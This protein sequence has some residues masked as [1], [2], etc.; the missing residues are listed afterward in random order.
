MAKESGFTIETWNK[1]KIVAA[2]LGGLLAVNLGSEDPPTFNILEWKPKNATNK[3]PIVLVGKGIVYD[4]GG[5]SLKP[6]ANSMDH[7]KC[8]M[9]GAAAVAGALHC[10]AKNKLDKHVIVLIPA[11]DNR[12]GKNAYVPGDVIKM[13]SGSTVEVLNTDAEGRMV[14]ADSLSY[15]K[16]YSPELVIDVATL[17]GSS[18]MALGPEGIVMM[19]TAGK[20]VKESIS[21]SGDQ[22]H[23][24]LV[25]F[26]IWDAYAKYLE[27]DIADLK[28]IGGR[29]AGSITAGKF[30]QHFT[31]YPW[32]HLDIATSAWSYHENGY[33]LKNGTGVGVRLLYHF[34]K[35][36]SA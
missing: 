21:N 2:K 22:V 33:R 27:S 36:Y 30:L 18:L 13:H 32:L 34:I 11:T 23:E 8:D 17:T 14:L 3:K 24:R 31:D 9:G 5:L 26:P 7:M 12:P 4:T 20:K 19:G 29:F 25:E 10:I 28:N 15:A 16:R 6:T 35:N 1:A